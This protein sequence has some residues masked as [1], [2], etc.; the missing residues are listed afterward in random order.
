MVVQV[1][2]SHKLKALRDLHIWLT[3]SI[4]S[5]MAGNRYPTT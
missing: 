4:E 2:T 1:G 5:L 3:D